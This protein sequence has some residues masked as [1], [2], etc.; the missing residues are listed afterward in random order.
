[1]MLEGEYLKD[2]LSQHRECPNKMYGIFKVCYY[3]STEDSY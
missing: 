1:M 3:F 2:I